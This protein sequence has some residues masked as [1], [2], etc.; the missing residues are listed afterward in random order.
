MS[1]Q[2]TATM[3]GAKNLLHPFCQPYFTQDG[4]GRSQS[5]FS[6]GTWCD[7]NNSH[8][9]KSWLIGL[10]S[11]FAFTWLKRNGLTENSQYTP[12]IRAPNMD[13]VTLCIKLMANF[14]HSNVCR[15]R[16]SQ[17]VNGILPGHTI[18][19]P[20]I[21]WWQMPMQILSWPW[22]YLLVFCQ[23]ACYLAIKGFFKLRFDL[24]NI[25]SLSEAPA[26]EKNLV[27]RV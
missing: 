3:E 11:N 26:A 2:I 13:P 18:H 23:L 27:N 8:E 21:D 25:P 5:H 6:K 15:H 22:T 7:S 9:T 24:S 10:G 19:G 20:V 14:A 12:I 16:Y 1:H 4:I 17:L